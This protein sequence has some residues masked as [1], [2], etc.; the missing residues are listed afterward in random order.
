MLRNSHL[1][2]HDDYLVATANFY[3]DYHHP[4]LYRYG[5]DGQPGFSG[6]AHVEVVPPINNGNVLITGLTGNTEGLLVS[7][8]VMHGSDSAF[9]A[10][11][12]TDGTLD[13]TFGNAG[14]VI[15][16]VDDLNTSIE[17]LSLRPDGKLLIAGRKTL[18]D[19]RSTG[20]VSQLLSNGTRDPDFNGG[21][22]VTESM[23]ESFYWQTATIDHLGRATLWGHIAR[24]KRFLIR[25]FDS[26]GIAE[27]AHTS[28]HNCTTKTIIALPL[29]NN[30][31]TASNIDN[32][33]GSDGALSSYLTG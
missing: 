20:W 25:R 17:H 3:Q 29:K 5:L 24:R 18:R 27:P 11:Y 16:K 10:R 15:F 32:M 33:L 19:G 1:I 12:L 7:G 13:K 22:P 14:H 6:S 4:R 21:N 9:I 23:D 31:L 2:I 30:I 28:T 8:Y 26:Q